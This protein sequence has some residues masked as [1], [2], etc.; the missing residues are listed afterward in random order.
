[1]G[2]NEY[3]LLFMKRYLTDDL[4][5]LSE[6]ASISRNGAPS[7]AA[8]SMIKA[9]SLGTN[10]PLMGFSLLASDGCVI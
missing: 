7:A 8:A 10:G 3:L 1:V 4:A 5:R 6:S 9:S 2:T